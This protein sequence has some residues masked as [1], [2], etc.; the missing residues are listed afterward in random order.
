MLE[1]IIELEKN[2]PDKN[3]E[4]KEI[5]EGFRER[6]GVL[7]AVEKWY[8][9]T[10]HFESLDPDQ[11]DEKD[12]ELFDIVLNL[13]GGIPNATAKVKERS[14]E[15]MNKSQILFRELLG[16]MVMVWMEKLNM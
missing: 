14:K 7:K 1:S 11:L 15:N 13:K 6:I 4:Q 5:L 9:E 10:A 16:N 3:L 2:Q 12:M 8:G